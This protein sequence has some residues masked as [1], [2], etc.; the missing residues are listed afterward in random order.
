MTAVEGVVQSQLRLDVSAIWVDVPTAENQSK[1]VVTGTD[2]NPERPKLSGDLLYSV[3]LRPVVVAQGNIPS[4]RSLSEGDEGAD[5]ALLQEFLASK[6]LFF[7]KQDG[8]F[9]SDSTAAVKLWQKSLGGPTDGQVLFG[10]I[11]YIDTLPAVITA[12]PKLIAKGVTLSG[13]EMALRFRKPTPEFSIAL[14]KKQ[15]DSVQRGQNVEIENGGE[16]WKAVVSEIGPG[17][18][19]SGDGAIA[20]LKA[21]SG[22]SICAE[23]CD[24][25]GS[26]GHSSFRGVIKLMDSISGVILPSAALITNGAG[27]T[28]IVR[29]NGV[30]VDVKVLG[31]A[32]GQ[33]A[34]SGLETGAIVRAPG[35][36]KNTQGK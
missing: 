9:R 34:I 19:Q 30:V 24:V 13:G 1:G 5:V 21:A 2:Q 4:F 35:Q 22:E 29:D 18:E 32:N 17:P 27:Q 12:D 6:G 16:S 36:P 7:G 14:S 3:N 23:R 33:T 28:Q 10:D 15:R 26:Q 20:T 31:S 11:V 25:V 8:K